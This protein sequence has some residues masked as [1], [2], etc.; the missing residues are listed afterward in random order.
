MQ[1]RMAKNC[2]MILNDDGGVA[3]ESEKQ[4]QIAQRFLEGLG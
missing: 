3:N 4:Y 2:E 1:A